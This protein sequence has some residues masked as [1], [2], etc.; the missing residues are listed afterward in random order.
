[1][2]DFLGGSPLSILVKLVFLS[3]LV[4][5]LLAFLDVTPADLVNRVIRMLRSIFGLSFDAVRDIGRW[6]LYGAMIVV[7]VWIVVRLFK[8]ARP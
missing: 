3:L 5:A 7:P 1:M 6:I 8:S 4:G 2:Q